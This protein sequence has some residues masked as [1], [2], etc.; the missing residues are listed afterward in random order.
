MARKW[1]VTVCIAALFLAAPVTLQGQDLNQ[2]VL[3]KL[4]EIEKR[5]K[6]LEEKQQEEESAEKQEKKQDQKEAEKKPADEMTVDVDE[7]RRQVD[8]LAEELEKVRSGEEELV[9]TNE[10]AKSLGIA[11]SAAS[12]YRK[13]RGVALAGYGEMLYENFANENE[14]GEDVDQTT[15]LD[16]LRAILYA[17][18]RFNDKFL[19]NSEI[20]V[21]HGSTDVEGSVSV[22]FA[23]IDYLAHESFNLRGGILL[24]P[25]GLVNEFHEPNVF[26]GARRPV[27]EQR[28]IPTTWRENGFG[29]HGSAGIFD[30]RAYVVNG[31]RASQFSSNGFRGGRQKGSEARADNLAF[32][33]RL[34]VNPT[35]GIFFGGSI[36]R[37]GSGQGEIVLEGQD[38]D[39]ATT[40]GELHG[41]VQLRGFD[42]RGLYAKSSI[43]DAV[44]LNQFLGL[45]GDDSVAESMQGGYFHVGYN[46]LNEFNETASLMPYY[47]FE[48][49]DTQDEVLAGFL[50]DP[51]RERVFNTLGLE[52][53]P[54]Y[55]VV[56][57]ADYQWISND[58]DTGVNQFN[59]ALGYSF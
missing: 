6:R 55:N 28:I 26:V 8:V 29:F 32:V 42:I 45:S 21:E 12:V 51:S 18:Y 46:V 34:D 56:L 30:Y 43:D 7:L 16:F 41:Q 49:L 31:L 37:G 25:M 5:L 40:I 50:P 57:K 53:K 59:V 36:Y 23:Y 35:P 27:V 54:I 22:E 4:E 2:E 9:V 19:F 44:E 10:D 3:K 38:F 11:P 17:G 13:R 52:Y 20:E 33:G 24:V 1:I 48:F 15:R 14:S 47:R 39:V 58:A